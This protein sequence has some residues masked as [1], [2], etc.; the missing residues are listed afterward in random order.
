MCSSDLDALHV[1]FD[2]V[3]FPQVVGHICKLEPERLF[4][5]RLGVGRGILLQRC[6]LLPFAVLEAAELDGLGVFLALSDDDYR[7]LL[8]DRRIGN[9]ARKIAHVLDVLAVEFDDHVTRIDDVLGRS[10]IFNAGDTIVEIAQEAVGSADEFQAK[11]DKL[12]SE[13]RRSALLLV[14]SADGELRFVALALQ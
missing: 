6:L 4:H 3:F 12:K 8:I 10:L 9:D 2:L 1:V 13:G 11:I 5:G 14:A 7:H